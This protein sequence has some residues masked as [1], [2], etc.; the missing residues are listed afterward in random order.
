MRRPNLKFGD[1]LRHGDG[2]VLRSCLSSSV[3]VNSCFK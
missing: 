3:V 2:T 1:A